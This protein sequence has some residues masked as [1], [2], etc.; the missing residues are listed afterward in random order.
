MDRWGGYPVPSPSPACAPLR[1]AR[2]MDARR[3]AHWR[4][5]HQFLATSR[6]VPITHHPGQTRCPG[7][8]SE[9]KLACL[10]LAACSHTL[11]EQPPAPVGAEFALFR[12]PP[13]GAAALALGAARSFVPTFEPSSLK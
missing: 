7:S 6:H 2:T 12:R 13:S 10:E 1:A 5:A 4:H 3:A 9:A 8:S 11:L